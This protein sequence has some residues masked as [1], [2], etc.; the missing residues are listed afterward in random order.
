MKYVPP[1]NGNSADENRSYWNFDA[2]TGLQGA[3][4]VAAAFEHPQREILAVI[5]AAGLTPSAEDLT[6]LR[7]AIGGLIAA[8]VAGIDPGTVDLSNYYTKTYV[9]TTYYNR[10][11]ID[12]R[13]ED[14]IAIFGN[15][16][17]KPTIDDLLA[18]IR[19][20]IRQPGIVYTE[21]ALTLTAEQGGSLVQTAGASVYT[22][23]LPDPT[24]LSGTSFDIYNI[25]SAD[26]VV[27]T[28]VGAFMGP[29]GNRGTA[30]V[31]PRGAN[32]RLRA[33]FNNWSV[34]DQ[35]WGMRVVSAA[36]SMTPADIGG[37]VQLGGSAFT[38]NLLDPSA[39][40]GARLQIYNAGAV[41]MTLSTP[42]GSFIGPG[43]TNSSTLPLAAGENAELRAGLV[44]WI[45]V[46]S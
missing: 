33:G 42:S 7:Q 40:S 20:L 44:N 11:E 8:A 25:S 29:R 43:G 32:M 22:V 13:I 38:F 15:F 24:P 30:Q 18:A 5:A 14:V 21:S 28:P 39:F 26:K 37:Y 45:A 12:D 9:D 23:T 4:P 1:I 46:V 17:N 31:L 41:T 6:Q 19:S 27:G 2:A 10:S 34:L 36:D 16:Y 35:S 3:I